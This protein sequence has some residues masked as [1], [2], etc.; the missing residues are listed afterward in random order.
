MKR[1]RVYL[2]R[3]NSQGDG[4]HTKIGLSGSVGDRI[5]TIETSY[6][7][8]A[9]WLDFIIECGTK[10]QMEEIETHFHDNFDEYSTKNDSNCKSSSTD[11]FNKVFVM[12]DI[13]RALE[14]GGY[15]NII[16]SDK[17]E[18]EK[19]LLEHIK[20]DKE[21]KEKLREKSRKIIQ[22]K[23]QEREKKIKRD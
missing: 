17:D 3:N 1:H 6:S 11:W 22:E 23:K 14:D 15:E 7:I 2:I 19:I 9:C 21:Q 16:I 20:Y 18:L 10:D 13:K 5:K 12:D 8:D 4:K